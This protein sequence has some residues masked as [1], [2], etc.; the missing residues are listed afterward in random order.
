M[1][2]DQTTLDAEALGEAPGIVT[3][4][5]GLW[6]DISP[7]PWRRLIA[8]ILDIH[9]HYLLTLFCIGLVLAPFY[10]RGFNALVA[11]E[12]S[13]LFRI[14]SP[15][16]ITLISIPIAT[17]LIGRSGFTVGKWLMGVRI[18]NSDRK[19]IGLAVAFR[20]E[21]LVWIR[22]LALGVPLINLFTMAAAQDNVE[23]DGATWD[24]ELETKVVHRP[25]G[26]RQKLT[27]VLF[28]TGLLLY[29][30]GS[31][32]WALYENLRLIAAS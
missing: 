2:A 28:G 32:L 17:V 30:L 22:G 25:D 18:V 8:R 29:V 3:E 21:L 12:S 31:R 13:T 27:T 5:E 11:I 6:Q 19:P 23:K 16:T 26:W 14:L 1:E 7:H 9:L 20:R 4:S 10:P 24:L 15:V